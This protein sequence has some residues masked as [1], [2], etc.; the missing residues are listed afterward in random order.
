[1]AKFKIKH[2]ITKKEWNK[3]HKD[4]K[5][6]IDGVPYIMMY[7]DKTGT[8]LVPVKIVDESVN[9]AKRGEFEVGDFVHFKSANKTG[10]VRGIKGDKVTILTMKGNYTGDI[11]DIKVL[12]QDNVNE[13][14]FSEID[15]MA[16]AARN[17]NDFV[18]EFY[19]DFKDFPKDKDTLKWLKSLYDG[20]S[21][22]ES[23]NENKLDKLRNAVQKI[24]R[25]YQVK[26]STHPVT[27]GQIEI[28]LG[29]GH[30]PDEDYN[31]IENL[32]SKLGFKRGQYS[33]F[34]ESVNEL[35]IN[36]PIMM[37]LRAAQMKRNQMA[38]KKIDTEKENKNAIKIK[39]LKK[40]RA[41]IM[42]DM[43]QEAEPEGGKIANRYGD[44]LN[45]IDNDIIKLGGNPMGESVNENDGVYFK[46]YTAAI[47][48]A[49]AAALKKGFEI[50]EDEMFTKV[51][52]NSKRPSVGK[53]TRVSLELTKAGK[54]QRKMLHIQ[55]Y[56]MKNGYELNSYIN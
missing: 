2:T 44:L 6:M 24:N 40:K 23:V 51:G 7:D 16:K 9:E 47:E 11:K 25:K 29:R 39:A 12:H 30:H 48:A 38:A 1:M 56:G 31:S 52:M 27:K 21:K 13:G 8:H 18:K 15:I 41:E 54:P 14:S 5:S 43:E 42:R 35:D 22:D 28:I 20:R 4:F 36:D 45:K 17:F 32:V 19:K 46:S 3:K 37:K 50:D 55:V 34:D 49:R 10:L 53:T 33:I 26:V